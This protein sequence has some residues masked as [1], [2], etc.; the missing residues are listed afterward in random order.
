MIEQ[1]LASYVW[2]IAGAIMLAIEA[3]GLPGAGFL[4]AG[5]GAL[6]TGIIITL[7]FIGQDAYIA[8]FAFWF[9]IS[10]IITA[11]LWKKLKGWSMAAPG[12]QYNNMIGTTGTVS[13]GG[14]TPGVPGSVRWSGT[15][16]LA[17]LAHG[18]ESVAEGATVEIV[19]V[20]G[21]TIIV[22]PR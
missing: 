2:L 3:L 21:T 10:A 19:E 11:C 8:Q 20:R 17:E 12:K 13:A 7:G 15:Q 4:F 5:I 14:L 9:I 18:Y 22:K 1:V 6:L 16:M